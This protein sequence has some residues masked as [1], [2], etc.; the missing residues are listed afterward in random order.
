MKPRNNIQHETEECKD[1]LA[2]YRTASKALSDYSPMIAEHEL[3]SFLSFG[4]N[5]DNYPEKL[6]D[7]TIQTL[8]EWFEEGLP[9]KV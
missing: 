2:E 4:K 3:G 9:E 7:I 5:Y 8:D 1:A 6:D